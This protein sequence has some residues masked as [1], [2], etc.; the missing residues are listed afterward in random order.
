MDV[1]RRFFAFTALFLISLSFLSAQDS[2]SLPETET[3]QTEEASSS[4]SFFSRIDPSLFVTAGPKLMVNTDSSTKSA[5]SPIMYSLGVGGDFTYENN[6]FMQV[7]ASFFTNYYLWDGERARPA[8][9]ENRTATALSAMLDLTGGYT[10]CLGE[11]QKHRLSLSGGL[12]FLLRHGILSGGVSEDDP[13]RDI[14]TT[15]G[16]DVSSINGTFFSGLNFLYPEFSVS[17]SYCL[18]EIWKIGGEFRTYLPIGS[19]K[20]GYGADGM[21][22]ALSLKISYR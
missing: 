10:F 18:S 7:H 16:D 15:A 1:M 21:I 14:D 3:T 8:E 13:N 20:D 19:L 5:P 9:V 2:E 22:F 6:V 11:S 17:Y 4:P 12:G